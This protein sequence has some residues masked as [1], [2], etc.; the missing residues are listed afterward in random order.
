MTV[1]IRRATVEDGKD[2]VKLFQ[3]LSEESGERSPISEASVSVYLGSTNSHIFL[4]ENNGHVSGLISYSTRP[5]LWHASTCC[6]I[7]EIIVDSAER[8]G[9]IGTQLIKYV[10]NKSEK[11]GHAEISLTV[12]SENK[13]AQRLYERLGINEVAVCMEKHFRR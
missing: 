8:G 4:A 10:L 5:D 12:S 13:Q 11:E 9:G 6:Y 3:Q 1:L 2:I 7:E